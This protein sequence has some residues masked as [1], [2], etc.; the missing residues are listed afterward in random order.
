MTGDGFL[1]TGDLASMDDQGYLTFGGRSRDV[2]I[3]GGENVYPAEVEDVLMEH[4][5][6]AAAVLVGLDDERLGEEVVGVIVRAEG[7]AVTGADLAEHLRGRVAR[8]KIPSR[9]RFVHEYPVTATGKIRRFLV[10]EQTSDEFAA[11]GPVD[12]REH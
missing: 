8:F 6:V 11:G 4:P 5:G 2:I 1:R 10:R 9:W 7:S 12:A 3:R